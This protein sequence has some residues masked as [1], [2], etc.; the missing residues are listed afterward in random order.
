MFCLPKT[1][2]PPT[3]RG[4][5]LPAGEPGRV[6]NRKDRKVLKG[7]K[8]G[9]TCWSAGDG[10]GNGLRAMNSPA[11]G[12]REAREGV[13]SRTGRKPNPASASKE[14]AGNYDPGEVAHNRAAASG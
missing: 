2:W 4:G 7:S 12:N 3:C 5:K 6:T 9:R 1:A 13:R 10:N 8:T 14:Q 11:A